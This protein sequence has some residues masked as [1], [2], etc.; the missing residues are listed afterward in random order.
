MVFFPGKRG[1][2][3]GDPL[4][5]YLF[6]LVMEILSL[7]LRR[8]IRESDQFRFHPKCEP[9]DIINMCFADDLLIFLHA[10]STRFVSIAN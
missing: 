1:L 5:P 10:V 9:L 7:I 8:R 2:R 6:T 3:Q 4:S